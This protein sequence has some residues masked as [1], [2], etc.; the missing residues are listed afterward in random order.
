MVLLQ[1]RPGKKCKGMCPDSI[2]KR[3]KV[4]SSSTD[5]LAGAWAHST[6][7]VQGLGVLNKGHVTE[8]I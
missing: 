4:G 2:K 1:I 6:L 5:N 3:T 7:D 8:V